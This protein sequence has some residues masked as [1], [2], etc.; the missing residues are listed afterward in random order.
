MVTKRVEVR[1]DEETVEILAELASE[2]Q[3]TISEVMRQAVRRLDEEAQRERRH[4]AVEEICA[5]EIEDMPDPEELSRQL[6][7]TYDVDLP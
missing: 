3:T 7:S 5:M 6:A 2:R 1:L 4:R